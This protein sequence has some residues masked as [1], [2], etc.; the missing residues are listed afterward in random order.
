MAVR[1]VGIEI[2]PLNLLPRSPASRLALWLYVTA[3]TA[4]HSGG[5]ALTISIKSGEG[6][7]RLAM[8]CNDLWTDRDQSQSGHRLRRRVRIDA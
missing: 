5:Q 7:G 4:L 3:Q 2:K 1:C 6:P 8:I